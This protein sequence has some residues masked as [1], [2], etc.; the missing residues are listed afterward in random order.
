M[1][2]ILS[3]SLSHF[4]QTVF[5]K[6]DPTGTKNKTSGPHCPR[7]SLFLCI[8][9]IWRV[10]LRWG[11]WSI[12]VYMRKRQSEIHTYI[13]THVCMFM[14][15]CKN[16]ERD[17]QPKVCM[18]NCHCRAVYLYNFTRAC[19]RHSAIL[20]I[21][22][23]QSPSLLY[24]NVIFSRGVGTIDIIHVTFFVSHEWK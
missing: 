18:C 12:C 13:H 6:G 9:S 1:Q 23:R 19:F 21:P 4:P 24:S 17:V 16:R 3:K 15:I 20:K 7:E 11:D 10:C 22:Q 2:S 8:Y 14:Y 5:S